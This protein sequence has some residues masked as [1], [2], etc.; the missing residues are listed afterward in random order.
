MLK[1]INKVKIVPALLLSLVFFHNATA[2]M[3][4][5]PIKPKTAGPGCVAYHGLE[6]CEIHSRTTGKTWLDRNLGATRTCETYDD[7]ECFGDYYQWGR[8]A[9]GHEK[10]TS[11]TSSSRS[12]S[13]VSLHNSFITSK[14]E[15]DW[16]QDN[17]DDD[18]ALR[19]A[20]WNPCPP[21]FRVPTSA[22][23]EAENITSSAFAFLMLRLPTSALRSYSDGNLFSFEFGAVWTSSIPTI[24]KLTDSEIFSYG[25][26]S[27]GTARAARAYGLPVRCLKQ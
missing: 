10:L 7:S 8:Y 4:V 25:S 11:E 26:S 22:E 21:G 5:I 18:G 3:Y 17:V 19:E 1:N 27:G 15:G 13:L 9:D 2:D 23:F 14:I 6:Y 24:G 20:N 12:A 16:T